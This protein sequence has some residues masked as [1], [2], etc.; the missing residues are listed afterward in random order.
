MKLSIKAIVI[1][2]LCTVSI[3]S[4]LPN[5][6]K[7]GFL[8]TKNK[9]NLG[10]DLQGGGYLLLK[11]DFQEHLRERLYN[12]S[13]E[14]KD[15]LQREKI[16]YNQLY[17]NQE[18]LILNLKNRDDIYRIKKVYKDIEVAD[19]GEHF[20]VLFNNAYI[21][22]VY[23]DVMSSSISNIQRRLDT[24]GTKEISIKSHGTD[25]I[26]LQIPGIYNTENIKS[27]L[28]KTAKLTFHLLEN[29]KKFSDINSFTTVLLHDNL[30]NTYPV[31]RKAEI[32]GDSLIDVSAGINQMG[33]AVVYFRFNNFATKKFAKITKENFGKPFAIVLDNIV[34]T[35]PV[36]NEPIM[37]GSGEISGKFS[38]DKA[39]E[40]AI[41]LKSGALPAPLHVIE[42]KTI[43]PSLGADSIAQG[44]I[45]M[46]TSILLV[47]VFIILVYGPFGVIAV[48]GLV[49]NI[50][51]I[52]FVLTLLQATLTLP[53]IAGIIL[54]IGMSVDANVLIFERIREEMKI[55][56]KLR[57]SIDTGFKNAMLTIFDSNITTLI[58]AAIMFMI[59][60]GSISGFAI[61]LSIGIICSM[62]SAITLTR[63]LIDLWVTVMKLK[64]INL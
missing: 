50:I 58:V 53:G 49:F 6:M 20:A 18:V 45:A 63:F 31:L 64:V 5:F 52:L 62:L 41:L 17:V 40:L 21:K 61:T 57:W 32:S 14:L 54:T 42:E 7:G 43:G 8:L 4:V 44:K 60:S 12:L 11:I 9:I 59:G 2:L 55:T 28:G 22:K 15:F 3:Y 34:L 27:L 37:G 26:S 35:A 48:I 47:A 23:K 1:F 13:D 29:V 39:K 25:K 36:I 51:F 30:G 46:I 56:N 16:S 24:S 33:K 38:L 19:K 10:L